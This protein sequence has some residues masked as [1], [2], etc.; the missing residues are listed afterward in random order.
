MNAPRESAIASAPPRGEAAA[1]PGDAR[2]ATYGVLAALLAAPPD[3]DALA[4]LARL[5]DGEGRDA[6]LAAAWQRLGAA[7]RD[8]RPQRLEREYHALF[9]G[10]V[11]GEVV[12]YASW[13]RTGAMMDRPL[14]RLRADLSRLGFAREPGVHEP[15]DHAAMLCAVMQALLAD[16]DDDTAGNFFHEHLQRWLPAF[17][18]DLG[19]AESAR[20]YAAVAELGG[21][22]MAL[23]SRFWALP[24]APDESAAATTERQ[25]DEDLKT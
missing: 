6:P 12:P 8:A 23:E 10:L 1:T 18:A 21:Q 2:A 4:Q 20:F 17:F 3:S 7:A 11:R 19:Q 15:E 16:Q 24:S 22:L 9:I 14:A 13:Y 5:P 25:A